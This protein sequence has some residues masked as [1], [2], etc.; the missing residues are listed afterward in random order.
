VIVTAYPAAASARD[1]FIVSRRQP[2]AAHDA[3][4]AH[5][6]AVEQEPAGTGE[7]AEVV[8]VFLTGRECPWRCAMCD[9]W[10]YT[11]DADT[12]TGAIPHQ[13][14]AALQSLPAVVQAFRPAI[15][16]YNAGSFFDPRAVPPGDY[17]AVAAA[18]SGFSRVI[19]E[20]H[21]AL[22]GPRVDGLLDALAAE[23][24]ERAPRLEVAMGLETAHPDALER[25]N[26]RMTIDQFRH[27]AGELRRRDVALRVFVLV[28]PPF[29]PADEQSL[30][31]RRSVDLAF[32]CGAT[33]V[34]LIPMRDGNGT[35]EA[36][37]AEG[38]FAG[39][40]LQRFEE[41]MD[42]ALD[43]ARGRVFADLWD[44]QRLASCAAC[45]APR[46][47]RLEQMNL[48]QRPAARV[49]CAQCARVEARA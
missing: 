36:L 18:V 27:A 42:S 41:A 37:G 1:A 45:F 34:S 12:P 46:K 29:V 44:V 47:A 24:V 9:L 6:V 17:R 2:R 31:L 23:A 35:V 40:T 28:A 25:L 8:T 20:S 26:K 33:A 49:T 39:P 38:L 3:W 32:D 30:W 4:R 43:R 5:G 21:P 15:K 13:I 19:V 16:L 14:R 10:K 22:I 7:L 11:T 48:T